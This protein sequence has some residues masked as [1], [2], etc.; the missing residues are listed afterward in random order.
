MQ[1]YLCTLLTTLAFSFRTR[2]LFNLKLDSSVNMYNDQQLS[3]N[4]EYVCFLVPLGE[5]ARF[6]TVSKICDCLETIICLHRKYICQVFSYHRQLHIRSDARM[7]QPFHWH[8]SAIR[9]LKITPFLRLINYW[10]K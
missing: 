10:I 2:L 5:E 4:V 9:K 7:T 6:A 1:G 8:L 3:Q